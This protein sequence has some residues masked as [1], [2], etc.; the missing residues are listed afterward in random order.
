MTPCRKIFATHDSICL[1]SHL[2]AIYDTS[3]SDDVRQ[4]LI[5]TEL[6]DKS[7]LLLQHY[8]VRPKVPKILLHNDSQGRV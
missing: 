6:L 4:P 1:R 7:Q 2:F 8:F 5:V 3:R